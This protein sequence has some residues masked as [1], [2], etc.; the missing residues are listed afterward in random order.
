MF[1]TEGIEKWSRVTFCL[2]FTFSTFIGESITRDEKISRTAI[3]FL[4][5]MWFLLA[6]IMGSGYGGN[7]KQFLINPGQT[8]PLDRKQTTTKIRKE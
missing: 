2:W 1:S 5:G 8:A 6:F 7:L 3:R 4:L